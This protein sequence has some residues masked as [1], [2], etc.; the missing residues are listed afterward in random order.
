MKQIKFR[1]WDGKEMFDAYQ[2]Q[3]LVSGK[4]TVRSKGCT[5]YGNGEKFVT[6]DDAILMQFTGLLDMDDKEIYSGDILALSYGIPPTLAILQVV[7]CIG[8]FKVICKNSS[9]EE[10]TMIEFYESG[11]NKD[12]YIQGNIYQSPELLDEKP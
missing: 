10:M 8:G 5:N 7:D 11:L 9:P 4:V 6:H 2:M 12:C 3:F 1:A